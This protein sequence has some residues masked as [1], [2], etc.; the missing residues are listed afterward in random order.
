MII[1]DHQMLEF[2]ERVASQVTVHPVCN[3]WLIK[4]SM[5]VDISALVY[6]KKN[7]L[8]FLYP[9]ESW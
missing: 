8:H 3:L 7:E 1:P 4:I 5:Q 2:V 9:W 6:S